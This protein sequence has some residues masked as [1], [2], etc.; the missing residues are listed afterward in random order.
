MNSTEHNNIIQ[1]AICCS[2][3]YAKKVADMFIKGNPC[4]DKEFQK[5]FLLIS[6]TES[7]GCYQAP[8]VETEYSYSNGIL[9]PT[10]TTTTY[11]NCLTEDQ[12]D[13]IANNIV[14]ICDLCDEY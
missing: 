5:L 6:Y 1:K 2:G 12:A 11:T 9:T 10:I 7:L 3:N 8:L 14:L 4:A 13:D